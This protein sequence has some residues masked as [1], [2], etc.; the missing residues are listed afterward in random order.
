[1]S[2]SSN[3]INAISKAIAKQ[4]PPDQFRIYRSWDDPNYPN[5]ELLTEAELKDVKIINLTWEGIEND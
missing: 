1:M 4:A 2:M 3:R 5:P